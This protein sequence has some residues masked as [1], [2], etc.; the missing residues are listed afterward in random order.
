MTPDQFM[1]LLPDRIEGNKVITMRDVLLS[2]PLDERE[3]FIRTLLSSE[4]RHGWERLVDDFAA[5][6][7]PV[8]CEWPEPRSEMIL[9][10]I[11]VRVKDLYS[12]VS[13]TNGRLYL[14]MQMPTQSTTLTLP[15]KLMTTSEFL[16]YY[17]FSVKRYVDELINPR[18][19]RLKRASEVLSALLPTVYVVQYLEGNTVDAVAKT[20]TLYCRSQDQIAE[21]AKRRLVRLTD[22]NKREDTC[23]S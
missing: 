7:D 6:R 10:E 2:M 18:I 5:V 3:A 11:D 13:L 16:F 21:W 17:G 19:K 8:N 22:I 14:R 9:D 4:H 20:T 1:T 12:V 23:Q 15:T